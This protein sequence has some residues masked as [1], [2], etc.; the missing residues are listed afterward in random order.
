MQKLEELRR[1]FQSI[2]GSHV[3]LLVFS[4]VVLCGCFLALFYIRAKS[5]NSR[6]SAS[7]AL[8]YQPKSTVN[9]QPYNDK[10]VMYVL[11]REAVRRQFYD[12][13][14]AS[15]DLRDATGPQDIRIEQVFRQNNYYVV[16]LSAATEKDAVTFVNMLADMCT[17]AYDEERLSYLENWKSALEQNRQ[18]LIVQIEQINDKMAQLNVTA[19]MV[20][21][22]KNY[23]Y[24]QNRLTSE[25]ANL[26]KQEASL[27]ALEQQYK[28][29]EK[30][31]SDIFP[32]LL[33]NIGKIHEYQA[34]LAKL[35]QE[36]RRL[37]EQFTERNPK[38]MAVEGR[39]ARTEQEFH[40]FLEEKGLAT[41]D[42]E[43]LES[44]PLVIKEL[45]RV[46][47]ELESMRGVIDVQ[48]KLVASLE[49]DLHDFNTNFPL[50]QDFIQQQ[51]K[52]KGSLE[53]LDATISDIN[54]LKPLVKDDLFVG[55]KARGAKE[56]LPFT[57]EAITISVLGAVAMTGGLALLLL[58]F[59]YFYGTVHGESEIDELSGLRYIG[60]I[61]SANSRLGHGESEH[62]FFSGV[63]HQFNMS[64][65]LPAV[66]LIG[67]LPGGEMRPEFVQ[68]FVED[69]AVGE[70]RKVLVLTLV[71]AAE[72]KIPRDPGLHRCA[73]AIYS[74]S[75]GYLPVDDPQCLQASEEGKMRQDILL[76]RKLFD[77]I[78]IVQEEPIDYNGLFLTQAATMC[79]ATLLAVG[80][81]KT[82]RRMLRMLQ[83]LQEKIGLSVMTVLTGRIKSL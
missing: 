26:A 46:S 6:F 18:E 50:R 30:S 56:K 29:L 57:K 58:V 38:V 81:K 60:I 70:E 55:E 35:D 66:L 23:E 22:E 24:L 2:L 21:P 44:A 43:F 27:R 67:S 65:P 49:K 37:K 61:P 63:S 68:S 62:A 53:K 52:L 42:M 32:L 3:V 64:K 10:Y 71:K 47:G 34:E 54:Y 8:H 25:K 33:P 12:S 83:E 74:G 69:C 1:T 28:A 31:K 75:N 80:V 20:A 76:L 36:I 40:E 39:R 17:A 59:G 41:T 5:S 48:T 72:F 15:G 19:V 78:C 82:P 45:D 13:L 9:V 16:S 7:V 79:D 4:L 73:L 14:G 51:A 11:S 77:L